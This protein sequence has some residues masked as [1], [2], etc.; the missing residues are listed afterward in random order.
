MWRIERCF[1]V[2]IVGESGV[3]N[4]GEFVV[5]VGDFVD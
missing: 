4:V 5:E 3:V 1:C 2:V